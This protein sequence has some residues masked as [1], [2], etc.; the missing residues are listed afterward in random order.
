MEGITSAMR[1]VISTR[2]VETP[3]FEAF[4]EA[5]GPRL[6]RAMRLLTGNTAEAEDC[7]QDAFFRVWQR[8]DRVG[9]MD[10]PSGYLYRTALNGYR[11][12]SRRAMFAARQ[13]LRLAPADD[14]ALSAQARD[15]CARWFVALTP[16][17]RT[18]VVLT[19]ILA[20][21]TDEAAAAMHV[22][23]GTVHALLSQARASLRRSM[24]TSDV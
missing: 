10:N 1:Q 4:F 15:M 7:C 16:R 24:E 13:A 11:R 6:F 3:A 19:E 9:V 14:P 17:Q 21:S 12:R 2:E 23:P 22:K 20:A 5:E 8:W 18:A